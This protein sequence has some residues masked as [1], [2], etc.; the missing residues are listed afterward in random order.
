MDVFLLLGPLNRYSFAVSSLFSADPATILITIFSILLALSVHEWAHAFAA[1][2]LGDPTAHNQGRLTINP[3]AHLDPLGALMFVFAG[4]GWA[5]PVPVN[6][7]YF[8]Q[9]KRDTAIV[10][11]AGPLSNLLMAVG[12]AIVLKFAGNL[13]PAGPL[14]TLIRTL[15]V[16]S[17]GMNVAL[18]AFNLLPIA[19]LDGSKVLHL[20]IPW[21]Y[22]QRYEDFLRVG[23]YILIFLLIF[24]SMLPIRIVSGWVHIVGDAV[25]R[26]LETTIGI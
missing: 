24:E 7:T 14:D 21:Q 25:L 16:T 6:H 20:F 10:A 9:P 23:P 2:R 26:L 15:A 13:L 8:A 11:L 17:L 19:P 4:F 18:F 1:Y 5:K 22:E 3:L 12:W